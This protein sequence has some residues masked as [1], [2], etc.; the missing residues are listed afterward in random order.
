MNQFDFLSLFNTDIRVSLEQ[1]RQTGPDSETISIDVS[2]SAITTTT[3]QL[4]TDS[5]EFLAV[6]YSLSPDF[7][8]LAGLHIADPDPPTDPLEINLTGLNP[9]QTYYYRLTD[10][11][12][13]SEQGRFETLVDLGLSGTGDFVI[14]GDSLSDTGNLFLALSQQQPPS[15]P[16]FQG[17][18]SN[19]PVLPEWMAERLGLATPT[20]ALAGGTNYAFAGA[21]TGAGTLPNGVPNLGQQI[22]SYLS[23]DRPESGDLFYLFAGANDLIFA[24]RSPGAIA[25]NLT[26]HISTLAEAGAQ[27]FIVSN[28]PD[29]GQLPAV[30]D[31]AQEELLT[32]AVL[33]TNQALDARFESLEQQFAIEILEL[34]IA[35][36]F[37][38]ILQN[39][40]Q[41]GLTNTT[42]PAL[43]IL[44]GEVVENPEEYLFW[45]GI[46]PT[47]RT[48]ELITRLSLTELQSLEAPPLQEAETPLRE[49]ESLLSPISE[50]AI[51]SESTLSLV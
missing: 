23:Q 46:H 49:P 13:S 34:D 4:A 16:Y 12:G 22:E 3:A 38:E 27:Q 5:G 33:A 37:E 2:V 20:P 50:L 30:L 35:G 7:E 9:N 11:Q 17:R 36:A 10:A 1:L 40:Q 47:T 29:I 39:P 43:D 24:Q 26:N 51:A 32:G 41:L 18:F 48:Y 45:D 31:P 8:T 21:Q 14:F 25:D 42:E 28:L 44:T 6:E 19:G 15:P